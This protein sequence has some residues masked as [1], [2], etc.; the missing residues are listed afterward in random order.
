VSLSVSNYVVHTAV[1]FAPAFKCV[2]PLA[3]SRFSAPGAMAGM[4]GMSMACGM[5]DP[6]KAAAAGI[7]F[8]MAQRRK[9]RVLFTQVRPED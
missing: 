2:H 3:V 9:R 5:M 6:S 1:S 4:A 7:Q 8:P